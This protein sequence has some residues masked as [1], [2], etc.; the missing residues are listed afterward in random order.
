MAVNK[1]HELAVSLAD[2]LK[3]GDKIKLR[4][5][6]YLQVFTQEVKDT[7]KMVSD[8]N[9]L[10]KKFLSMFP[11]CKTC[12]G[13]QPVTEGNFS[14]FVSYNGAGI[15]AIKEASNIFDRLRTIT[16]D[17][18]NKKA[19]FLKPNSILITA[20]TSNEMKVTGGKKKGKKGKK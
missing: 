14:Y 7:S 15:K 9:D 2:K 20:M 10:E 4:P 1:V 5:S 16:T 6:Q 17:L 11:G 3:K 13:L 12:D 8:I 18:G 19:R